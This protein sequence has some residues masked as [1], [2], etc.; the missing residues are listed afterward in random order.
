MVELKYQEVHPASVSSTQN[1]VTFTMPNQ[2]VTV[3]A[4]FTAA[5]V[6]VS[7]QVVDPSNNPI[8]G[9]TVT[10]SG[11]PL[12]SPITQTTNSSGIATF[13]L[14]PGY[15][16]NFSASASGYQTAGGPQ[17]ISQSGTYTITL[18]QALQQLTLI[19]QQG[20]NV[21]VMISTDGGNTWY[22]AG[23]VKSGN[24]GY[25]SI[26]PGLLVKLQAT[27]NS[28]YQFAGWTGIPS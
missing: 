8:Q 13:N 17:Y 3:T 24:T 20:G 4:Y 7:I 1:P 11:G 5:T 9:A 25:I 12:T 14:Q 15:T 19:V 10:V 28:G 16:Y 26:R 27:P 21:D 6:S 23:T 2:S 22:A 18:G